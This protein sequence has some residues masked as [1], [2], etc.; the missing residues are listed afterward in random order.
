[1]T[2]L[3]LIVVVLL[4]VVYLLPWAALSEGSAAFSLNAYDLAEW[5][6]LHPAER[7]SSPIL[8]T[9]LLLRLPLAC[10]GVALALTMPNRM[11][12]VIVG[13]IFFAA[14]LPPLTFIN[15]RDD[16]NYQQQ[17][18]IAALVLVASVSAAVFMRRV[19]VLS[20]MGVLFALVAL[21]AGA[22]GALRAADL[23]R[24]FGVAASVT[25]IPVISAALWLTFAA[26]LARRSR[27]KTTR[28][29]RR[30][31]VER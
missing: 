6:S 21:G 18:M 15:Q 13:V 12:A 22:G 19:R 29:A 28:L 11:L 3:R 17:F 9:S 24:G 8:L 14:L 25:L 20:V 5:A 23:L 2:R 10:I 27:N 1:M 7:A 4:L 26:T 16:P 30:A 31:V